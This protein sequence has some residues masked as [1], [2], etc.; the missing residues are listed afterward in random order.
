MADIVLNW[1]GQQF[2][3]PE[4]RAFEAGAAVEEV[5]TLAQIASWG[6]NPKFFL[7]ARAMGTL[8][9]FAGARVSDA[10][11]KREIDR[12]I[13][14]AVR[15]GADK[16]EAEQLF[17]TNAVQQ[18]IQVLFEGAPEVEDDGPPPG[19]NSAS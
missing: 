13:A 10:E 15:Q 17:A 12:S 9:R 2:R 1:R 8:L 18:L 7:L 4:S 3:I 6:N 5:V 14:R 19:E 16:S 11:V